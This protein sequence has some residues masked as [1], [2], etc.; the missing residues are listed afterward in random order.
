ML[1][2]HVFSGIPVGE[3]KDIFFPFDL[4]STLELIKLQGILLLSLCFLFICKSSLCIQSGNIRFY[5]FLAFSKKK[6]MNESQNS[7]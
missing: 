2:N 7:F 6:V 3:W 5:I 4:G 1:C